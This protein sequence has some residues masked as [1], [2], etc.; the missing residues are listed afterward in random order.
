VPACLPACL[1]RLVEQQE[2]YEKLGSALGEKR[3]T[4]L[5]QRLA[6]TVEP[7]AKGV[8]VAFDGA[9]RFAAAQGRSDLLLQL[10]RAAYRNRRK[11]NVMLLHQVFSVAVQFDEIDAAVKMLESFHNVHFHTTDLMLKTLLKH[12][13]VADLVKLMPRV[14]VCLWLCVC[15]WFPGMVYVAPCYLTWTW[16]GLPGSAALFPREAPQHAVTIP[17]DS[18]S[19]VGLSSFVRRLGC[20]AQHVTA[21][22]GLP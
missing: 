15:V 19:L 7:G 18:I 6:K 10:G 17:G 2:H 12:H 11:G 16:F 4:T 5:V 21:L 22:V 8:G 9:A 14:R 20:A 1:F 3:L 13:R